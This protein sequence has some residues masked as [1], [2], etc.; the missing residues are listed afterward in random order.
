MSN[1]LDS[2]GDDIVTKG[3]KEP[4]MGSKQPMIAES[5]LNSSRSIRNALKQIGRASCRERG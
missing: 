1:H 5:M 2:N 4:Y 3:K